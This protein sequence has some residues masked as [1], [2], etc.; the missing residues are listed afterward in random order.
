[1]DGINAMFKFQEI[2]FPDGEKHFPF[3]MQKNGEIVNGKGTYQI[4]KLREAMKW[5]KQF[6]TAVD[7]GAHVGLWSMHLAGKFE[8]VY[9]FEPVPQFQQCYAENVWQ[10]NCRL[11][12]S[13][14][15]ATSG[16]VTMVVPELHG[17][18]D[19][20]GTHIGIVRTDG[21]GIAM[22]TLDSFGFDRV[23]FLKLD[24]EG[25]ELEVLKGAV[26]TLKRCKPCVI[27]E[28]KPHK[29]LPNFGIKGTPAVTFLQ[30]MGAIVRKEMGGDWIMS[31]D[32]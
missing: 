5:C 22:K 1:M 2:W 18:I 31:W 29:L 27:V 11:N 20:G 30:E 16:H 13:A 8:Y 19:S 3:W 9:A 10:E 15:G 4:K 24:V 26:E 6:R 25:Y 28:Q 21:Q 7:V 32:A 14:L 17:G 23:D 12:F